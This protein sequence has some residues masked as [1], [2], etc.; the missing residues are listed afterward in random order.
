MDGLI[1]IGDGIGAVFPVGSS[2]R[3]GGDLVVGG[4]TN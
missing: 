4:K 3:L 2:S 1:G